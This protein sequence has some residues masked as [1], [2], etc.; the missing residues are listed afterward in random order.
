MYMQL[1]VLCIC[2]YNVHLFIASVV[3]PKPKAEISGPLDFTH[4]Q[5]FGQHGQ[6][7]IQQMPVS[8]PLIPIHTHAHTCIAIDKH[9]F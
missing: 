7:N 5:H 8:H 2:N 9:C 6:M 1:Y 4:I 3:R